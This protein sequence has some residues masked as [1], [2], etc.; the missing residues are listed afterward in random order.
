MFTPPAE[1]AASLLSLPWGEPLASC[2]YLEQKA[3]RPVSEFVA[4]NRT[5]AAAP[6]GAAAQPHPAAPLPL[7]L[8]R[9]DASLSLTDPGRIFKVE[10]PSADLEETLPWPTLMGQGGPRVEDGFEDGEDHRAGRDAGG[11][12]FGQDSDG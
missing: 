8:L 4:A 1:E 5:H 3:G 11:G 7:A 12:Q 2:A 9:T 6:N 10:S